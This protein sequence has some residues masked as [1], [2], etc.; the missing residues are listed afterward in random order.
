MVCLEDGY[1][2]EM[3]VLFYLATQCNILRDSNPHIHCCEKLG[4]NRLYGT[5]NLPSKVFLGLFNIKTFEQ[6]NSG[7]TTLT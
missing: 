7:S 3:L 6:V 5:A 4:F 2:S 1:S